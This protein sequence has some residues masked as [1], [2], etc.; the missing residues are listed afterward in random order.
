MIVF[1]FFCT[2]NSPWSCG[3]GVSGGQR[4]PAQAGLHWG[5]VYRSLHATTLPPGP[6][7]LRAEQC[8]TAHRHLRMSGEHVCRAQRRVQAQ[9]YHHST[10]KNNDYGPLKRGLTLSSI[11]LNQVGCSRVGTG[12]LWRFG[13]RRLAVYERRKSGEK[14]KITHRGFI[15]WLWTVCKLG[16]ILS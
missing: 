11:C 13:N 8:A 3:G 2:P 16:L 9:R 4:L 12:T 14:N 6:D 7:L 1:V 5:G 10:T 15:Q